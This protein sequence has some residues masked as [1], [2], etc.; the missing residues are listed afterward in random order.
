MHGM[1]RDSQ[2]D[3]PS[4]LTAPEQ[5]APTGAE[6][7]PLP[8]SQTALAVLPAFLITRLVV[9]LSG[10]SAIAIWGQESARTVYD[11]V[12]YTTELGRAFSDLIAPLARWDSVWFLDI[13]DVGY[14]TSYPPRAAFF[15]LYPVL[16]RVGGWV[17]GSP[18]V[19]GLLISFVSAFV[20][21]MLVHRL[22]ELELGR[23]AAGAAVWALL[24]FPG[25]MWLTAVYSEGLFLLLS[26]GALLAAR[27]RAWLLAGLLGALASSTRSAG[28]VLIVPLAVI[29]WSH[30]RERTRVPRADDPRGDPP[31]GRHRPELRDWRP[32]LAAAAVPL[33]AIVFA[34]SLRIAG[35]SWTVALDQQQEWGRENV[36]PFVGILRSIEA[37]GDGLAQL[38]GTTGATAATPGAEWMNPVL[39]VFLVVGLCVLVGVARRLPPAYAAY[40]ACALL[41]PLSSPAVGGGEPLMSLPRFLGVLFPLAMWTGW[42]VTRGSCQR[43]RGIGLAVGGL[44]LL[45]GVSALTARWT[46]VA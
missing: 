46:F 7:R 25:S 8:W 18:L 40:T 44:L 34:I 5:V 9:V 31:P 38:L 20:G 43:G 14:P 6:R 45:A 29:A 27:Q 36:G 2:L 23:R 22:T 10:V 32:L 26:A 11:P 28:V 17:V 30:Y 19:A 33:G 3:W 1:G 15:P 24:A 21:A 4:A 42:W 12:G 35:H 16:M 13:A 41:L 39:L 37:A